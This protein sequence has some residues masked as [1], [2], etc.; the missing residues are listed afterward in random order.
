MREG[1]AA[2]LR[3]AALVVVVALGLAGVLAGS[4]LAERGHRFEREFGGPCLVEPCEGRLK[5]PSGVAVSEVGASE[6][7]VYVVDKGGDRVVRYSAAG[8]FEGE[9]NGSGLLAGEGKAAGSG[10]LPDE[11]PTGRFDEPEGIAVDNDPASPSV[12]DLYVVDAGHQVVDKF[13]ATGAYIGQITAKTTETPEGAFIPLRGIAVD[14][15]GEVW[16]A[17]EHRNA[18]HVKVQGV[19]D[20]SNAAANKFGGFVL[21]PTPG[22]EQSG[23]AV[24]SRDDLYVHVGGGGEGADRIE[25][26]DAKGDVISRE[27]DE[28]SVSG[29]AIDGTT[30]DVYVDN[31]QSLGRF[32]P[33][34]SLVERLTVPGGHG[35]AVAVDSAGE[36]VLVADSSTDFVDVFGPEPPGRPEVVVGSESV[37]EVTVGSATLSAEVDPRSNLGEEPTSYSFEYGECA[38]VAACPGTN[39]EVTVPEPAGE[40]TANY[41]PDIV[42]A[43]LQGLR[44]G[45]AYHFRILARNRFDPA[46]PV[47]GDE[48]VFV[49]QVPGGG[50]LD[51][52]KWEMVSPPNKH[53]ANLVSLNEGVIQAA[54]GG[55]AFTFL[56]SAPTEAGAAGNTV[57]L[58][59]LARRGAG[60]WESQDIATPNAAAT[61]AQVTHG[62]E[63]R[64]FSKDLSSALVQPIG[65]YTP[66]LSP[67]ASEQTI[68][69]RSD[70][71]TG[72][73]GEPCERLCYRPLVMGANVPQGTAFGVNQNTGEA[74]VGGFCGPQFVGASSNGSN[75]VLRSRVPLAESVPSESLYEWSGGMLSLVSVLPESDGGA[76]VPASSEPTLGH[77]EGGRPA[78]AR[79]TVSA[80]GSRVVWSEAQGKLRLFLRDMSKAESVQVGPAGAVFATA[81]SDD[82][83]VFYLFGGDLY[84]F[85]VA[86]GEG[87]LSG[88]VTRLTESAGV[89]GTVIGASEDGSYVYF[90]ANGVLGNGGEQGAKPGDCEAG[91]GVGETCNLY[92]AHFDGTSWGTNF[93]ATLSGEDRHDW[94]EVNGELARLTARV[95]PNG[96]RL[97]FMSEESLS[98]YDNRDAV[99]GR[100]DEEV[101]EYDAA[102]VLSEG[103]G[104]GDNPMC[105]SCVPSGARPVGVEA[106]QLEGELGLVLGVGWSG[107]RT[108]IAADVPEWTPYE[109]GGAL[110][111]SRYLSDSGRLFFDGDDGLVAADRN[112]VQD[113]YEFEPA[114]VGSCAAS[115]SGF[116]VVTNGCVGLVSSGASPGES[117]FLDASESG[118][119]VF[120]LTESR[121]SSADTDSALDVYDAHECTSLAPCLPEQQAPPAPCEAACQ[122]A[123]ASPE[124][125]ARPGSLSYEGPGDLVPAPASGA[126]TRAQKLELALKACRRKPR[127]KGKRAACERQARKRY[128]PVK[129]KKTAKKAKRARRAKKAR[130]AEKAAVSS[131]AVVSWLVGV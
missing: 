123:A 85:T 116:S 91:H 93:I 87:S 105:V 90:V 54:A 118:G 97:A 24:D 44:A 71:P 78:D 89:V 12:G 17:E 48:T 34:G 59:V 111:Q 29:V 107:T 36:V 95:S 51:G 68:F 45:T 63:Y 80:D 101:F 125:A 61:G 99:S 74:C 2:T 9:F 8:A 4:A 77:A 6:G 37:S 76:P 72:N 56:A 129:A 42:T 102:L 65:P 53:G 38:S 92:V 82:S 124:V 109:L 14:P 110:Y 84:L 7:D 30:E 131:G 11:E 128:G 121:L 126:L 122:A 28:E 130:K 81:S 39:F 3:R 67:E 43:R 70:F 58:Q 60:G 94:G 25:E 52:R 23:L 69:L 96:G 119:D 21:L 113:V 19:D 18:E 100:A 32:R 86:P 33:D 27:V 83:R 108:W 15:H 16:V 117:A 22:F 79:D 13:S 127:A 115:S 5:E 75:V 40:L 49:T 66:A 50:L 26:F 114:G 47:E 46:E 10:G 57:G 1:L 55:D 106:Q 104:G 20:L 88:T 31:R 112:G 73:P 41:E 98:G 35:S 103:T 120:F 64:F 62:Y